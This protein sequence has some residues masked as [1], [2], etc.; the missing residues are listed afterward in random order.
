MSFV[1]VCTYFFNPNTSFW[2][3]FRIFK[4]RWYNWKSLFWC[5]IMNETINIGLDISN[6]R[7]QDYN[8]GLNMKGKHQ[9]MQ[10]KNF[11]H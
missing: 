4:N 8:K 3:F 6:L 1:I 9:G 2:I 11:K 7:V 10:K 5:V